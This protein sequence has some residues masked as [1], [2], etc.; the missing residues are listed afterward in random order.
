VRVQYNRC[1][2]GLPTFGLKILGV[3]EGMEIH[4]FSDIIQDFKK[5]TGLFGIIT[6][7]FAEAPEDWEACVDIWE[8]LMG[9]FKWIGQHLSLSAIF[10]SLFANIW[11]HF[12][13]IAS[14]GWGL[15]TAIFQKDYYK[16]GKDYGELIMLLFD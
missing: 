6:S 4:S 11:A 3:F 1:I 10:G 8:E 14:D 9:T 12:M 7:I 2:V 5:L 16:I 13:K 15:V